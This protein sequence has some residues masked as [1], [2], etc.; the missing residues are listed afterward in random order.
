MLPR[1]IGIYG[2]EAEV[3]LQTEPDDGEHQAF[4]AHIPE[5][6]ALPC[7]RLGGILAFLKDEL[8][9]VSPKRRETWVAWS[10]CPCLDMLELESTKRGES[11]S[12]AAWASSPPVPFAHA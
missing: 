6:Q 9:L 1:K 2:S 4:M 3:L 11:G 12:V 10:P 5:N 7:V 8:G